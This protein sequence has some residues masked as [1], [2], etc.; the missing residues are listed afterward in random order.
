MT[1]SRVSMPQPC[2]ESD[3]ILILQQHE[4]GQRQRNVSVPNAAT[5]AVSTWMVASRFLHVYKFQSRK[6]II[7]TLLLRPRV[8]NSLAESLQFSDINSLP[9]SS[10][11]SL[12]HPPS[13]AENKKTHD[14]WCKE[15]EKLL[16]LLWVE[17]HDQLHSQHEVFC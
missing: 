15:E 12:N 16:V 6:K 11:T 17:K 3:H 10:I 2:N 7:Q 8:P 14:R 5:S 13:I 1:C 9:V 4:S